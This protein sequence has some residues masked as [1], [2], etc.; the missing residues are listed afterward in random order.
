MLHLNTIHFI[1]TSWLSFVSLTPAYTMHSPN[2]CD[3]K[4]LTRFQI[5]MHSCLRLQFVAHS[6]L[7]CVRSCLKCQKQSQL[8]CTVPHN[9]RFMVHSH[10]KC[11]R[12]AYEVI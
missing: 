11:S 2:V 5:A 7:Q 4:C 8:Q 1:P 10:Q 12:S 9:L 6:R 3:A